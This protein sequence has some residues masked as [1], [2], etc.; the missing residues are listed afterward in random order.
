[1]ASILTSRV[2]WPIRE[3]HDDPL[4]NPPNAKS[5]ILQAVSKRPASDPCNVLFLKMIA[6]GS[7]SIAEQPLTKR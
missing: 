7:K 5:K 3:G 6:L 2:L 4:L 1:M